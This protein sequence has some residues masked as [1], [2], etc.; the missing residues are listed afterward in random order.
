[1]SS[2][3]PLLAALSEADRAAIVAAAR[4][5][6][7]GRGEVLFHEGDPGDTL[8]VIAEGRIAVRVSTPLGDTATLT[9]L[10]PGAAFGELAL[11]VPD[12]V[13]TA[14]AVA[15]EPSATWE[16][17]RAAF[18]RLRRA[19]PAVDRFLVELLAGRVQRLTGALLEAL[20][21]PAEQRVLR[22]LRTLAHVYGGLRGGTII[23]CT[24]E[25]VA[26][27]AGVTRPT[28]NQVLRGLAADGVVA[29]RRGRIELVDPD[30]LDRL[31]G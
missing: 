30:A 26:S 9:V 6:T 27:M 25:D 21:L 29:V 8:H 31:A 17:H 3:W 20:Y 11:V 18:E 5:R 1:M 14:T 15:L 16:V 28:A 4:R 12:G 23:R 2:D 13:R 10:G 22:R 24:Q 19:S 7:F